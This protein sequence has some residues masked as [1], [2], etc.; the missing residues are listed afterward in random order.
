MKRMTR[1]WI[2]KAEGDYQAA[3]QTRDVVRGRLGEGA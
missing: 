3:L 2:E 1:E